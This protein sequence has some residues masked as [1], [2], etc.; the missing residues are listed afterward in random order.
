MSTINLKYIVP[1]DNFKLA[2]DAS[3]QVK[4]KLKK[5]GYNTVA[6]RRIAIA[7]Y[8]AEINMVIHANGGKINVDI[9]PDKVNVTLQDNG[10]GIKDLEKA[11]H[12]GYSTAPENIRELGF[13]AGM[14]LPNMKKYT[15]ELKINTEIGKGTTV[16]L[17]VH[18]NN[19]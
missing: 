2:G 12:E 3:C 4:N 1:G 16:Y 13:G 17:S 8:E 18:S 15:D 9:H 6:I 11:M 5:L 14:G 19:N 10:P 7:M